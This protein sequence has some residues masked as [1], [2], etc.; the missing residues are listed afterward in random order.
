METGDVPESMDIGQN[1]K[2]VDSSS[3]GTFE[4][5]SRF[6]IL[7]KSLIDV[8]NDLDV[9]KG[10]MLKSFEKFNSLLEDIRLEMKEQS[11]KPTVICLH[12][13]E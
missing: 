3:G 5:N 11:R 4:I 13:F 12:K 7:E 9:F 8:S 2:K 6:T 1:S 10:F